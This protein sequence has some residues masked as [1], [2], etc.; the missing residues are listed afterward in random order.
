M[1]EKNLILKNLNPKQ[2]EAATH[3]EGPLLIIAGPGSGKTRTITHRI[4][5]MI[6]QGV[7]PANILAV[8]FTNKAAGEMEQRVKKLL[9]RTA[10]EA[11]SPELS[12]FHSFC[13]KV[14]RREAGKVNLSAGYVIYDSKDSLRLIKKI[15]NELGIDPDTLNPK[16]VKKKIETAKNVLKNPTAFEK[17]AGGYPDTDIAKVYKEYQRRLE[18]NDACD[19]ADLIA[20]SVAAFKKDNKTLTR[21]Q[22]KYKYIMVDEYQDTNQAQYRLTRLLAKKYNNIAVVGDDAQSVYG[23]RGADYRNILNFETDWPEAEVVMLEQNYR[24]TQNILDAA[25]CV[26][27]KN[28]DQKDKKLWTE[29]KEGPAIKVQKVPD[30]KEEARF[31]ISEI[32][33]LVMGEENLSLSDCAI[34]FRTNAQS[35]ALEEEFVKRDIPYQLVGSV[36]FYERREIKD[37]LAYLRLLYNPRD[38]LSLERI[39]NVPRRGLGKKTFARGEA[40]LQKKLSGIEQADSPPQ[41]KEGALPTRSRKACNKFL[42]LLF[43]LYKKKSKLPLSE[44]VDY[45]TGK[46]DYKAYIKDDTEQGEQRWDNIQELLTVAEQYDDLEPDQALKEFLEKVSLLT[47]QDEVEDSKDLVNLMTLHAVKGLEFPCVFIV[48]CEEGLFPHSRSLIDPGQMA[49]ERRL[50]YVGITRAE[51]WIYLLYTESRKLY[52]KYVRNPRS[53]FIDDID[54]ELIE[55]PDF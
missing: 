31:V 21:Y 19:F 27:S 20:K 10:G 9:K 29:E 47:Q 22:R 30:E 15:M 7:D 39:Y 36:R 8:T 51:R 48:G 3:I 5:Y 17:Q 2:A 42:E 46:I 33:E 6:D 53:R 4:A 32:K 25:D 37:L 50:C 44:L 13:A 55:G 12:T 18:A 54:D 34:L 16:T 35:R 43:D 49:E 26:I 1:P 11:V 40:L 14:L 41:I 38:S 24:S 28:S 52:G 23:F 45:I